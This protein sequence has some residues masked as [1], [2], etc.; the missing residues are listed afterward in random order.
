M[1]AINGYI[2]TRSIIDFAE[3]NRDCK[4]IHIALFIYI[5]DLCNRLG[6]KKEFQLPTAQAMEVLSIGNRNTYSEALNDLVKWGF[7]EITQESLNQYQ[8][9]YIKICQFKNEQPLNKQ[10]TGIDTSSEL[11]Y[12][13]I[14]LNKLNKHNSEQEEIFK[15]FH[16]T[17]PGTKPG[18]KTSF[19]I[20]KKHSD[21]QNALPDLLGAITR[22]ISHKNDLRAGGKFCPEYKHLKTWL[23]QRCWEDHLPETSPVPKTAK[24]QTLTPQTIF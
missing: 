21:W 8:A 13:P 20:L 9:R 19:D 6:W 24:S 11:I 16:L 22:E 17:Y 15:K 5:C 1:Q 23:N 2:L 12:K 18:L 4:Y 7:I 10:S 14:K 3:G